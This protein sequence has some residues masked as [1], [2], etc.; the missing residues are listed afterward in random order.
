MMAGHSTKRRP[1]VVGVIASGADLKRAM[2]MR[3]PP[4]LFEL[5]L[6]HLA[7]MT[8]QVQRAV[9]EIVRLVPV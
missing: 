4:D 1:Q 3:R 8:D 5:R 6:D 7:D 9:W 2:R